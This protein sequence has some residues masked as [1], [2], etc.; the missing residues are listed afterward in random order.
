MDRRLGGSCRT[1]R[2]S[3]RGRSPRCRLPD[4]P[5]PHLAAA[6]ADGTGWQEQSGVHARNA[7]RITPRFAPE[8]GAGGRKRGEQV[9]FGGPPQWRLESVFRVYIL[10]GRRPSGAIISGKANLAPTPCGGG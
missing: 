3:G 1:A 4:A 10:M 2:E 9:G 7:V 8:Q 5:R 6:G